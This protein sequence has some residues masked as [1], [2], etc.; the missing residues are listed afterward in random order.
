MN[1]HYAAPG[2]ADEEVAWRSGTYDMFEDVPEREHDVPSDSGDEW[3][4]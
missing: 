1:D 2:M 3:P 4:W